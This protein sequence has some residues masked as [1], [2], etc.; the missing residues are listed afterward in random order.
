[1]SRA[2]YVAA[3]RRSNFP[4]GREVVKA[5]E[6]TKKALAC[7]GMPKARGW[8]GSTSRARQEPGQK[9]SASFTSFSSFLTGT[10]SFAIAKSQALSRQ[11]SVPPASTKV[12]RA[13]T[14]SSP[15]PPWYSGGKREGRFFPST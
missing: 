3:T 5:E 7:L 14:P 12:L 10:S 9:N 15:I 2:G 4:E 11:T 1:M 8:E 13:V 6:E